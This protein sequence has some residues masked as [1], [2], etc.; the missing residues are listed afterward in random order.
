MQTRKHSNRPAEFSGVVRRRIK[1][2]RE[3]RSRLGTCWRTEP[4]RTRI[5]MLERETGIEPA[6]SSLGSWHS[7]AELLPLASRTPEVWYSHH[8]LASRVYLTRDLPRARADPADSVFFKMISRHSFSNH[9]FSCMR[10]MS[11]LQGSRDFVTPK[12]PLRC[13]GR[14]A[15]GRLWSLAPERL[16]RR[17]EVVRRPCSTV[18]PPACRRPQGK[19]GPWNKGSLP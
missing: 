5:K 18:V 4:P 13:S 16:H 9:P 1:A 11:V 6:T 7:T 10:V 12:E 3:L 19:F 15:C 8:R 14:V 17:P 2:S